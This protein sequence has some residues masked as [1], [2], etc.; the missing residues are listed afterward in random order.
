MEKERLQE[1][2][3][4]RVAM[5]LY[6]NFIEASEEMPSDEARDFIYH[7]VRYGLNGEIPNLEGKSPLFRIAWKMCVPKLDSDL[8]KYHNGTKGGAPEGNSNR[9]GSTAINREST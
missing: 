9:K 3:K 5:S 6:A 7:I 2:V 4:G 1:Y 8:I